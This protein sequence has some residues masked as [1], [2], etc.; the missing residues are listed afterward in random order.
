MS[1]R[2]RGDE[3]GGGPD[4]LAAIVGSTPNGIYAVDTDLGCLAWNPGMVRLTG[5]PAR[6]VV[7]RPVIDGLPEVARVAAER[8]LREA[9][10]GNTSVTRDVPHTVSG[11]DDVRYFDEHYGPLRDD[12]R[13][14]GALVVLHDVTERKLLDEAL[15]HA[16]F[17]DPLTN[18]ANRALFADRI[19][20]ALV[21]TDR[22]EARPALVLVDLDD[23]K[24]VN[25]RFGHAAGDAVLVGVAERLRSCLRPADTA[26]RL[27][28]DEF[29]LLLEDLDEPSQASSVAERVMR[30]LQA[31][32]AVA[33]HE[34]TVSAS[35]GVAVGTGGER[36]DE[37]LR[38]ADEAMYLAKR[39]GKGRYEVFV[40]EM[41]ARVLD[42]RDAD[43]AA[44]GRR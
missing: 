34:V 30:V 19:E 29:C 11:S 28:G 13:I 32:F 42:L 39:R 17:H 14:V 27:G 33:G 15:R 22:R 7:G 4:V 6:R 41:R 18:L 31:P 25:D 24:A 43:R 35:A 9:L 2:G 23:F 40:P 44:R 20:H 1:Q 12:A 5:V 36:G 8:H 16:A 10:Q 26:A 38:G 3:G 37:L 21:R